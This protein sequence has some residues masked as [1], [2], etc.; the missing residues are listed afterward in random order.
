M[1]I[2]SIEGL[3]SPC[4]LLGER[5]GYLL[6]LLSYPHWP[7]DTVP[8]ALEECE[9]LAEAT[10]SEGLLQAQESLGFPAALHSQAP[11]PGDLARPCRDLTLSPESPASLGMTASHSPAL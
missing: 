1:F 7:Q 4:L 11:A 2:S 8:A 10:L 5:K 6:P 3:P 9:G